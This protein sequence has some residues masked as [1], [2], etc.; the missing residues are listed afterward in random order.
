MCQK[1]MRKGLL[2]YLLAYKMFHRHRPT[3]FLMGSH[4][5]ICSLNWHSPWM[6]DHVL[7]MCTSL[8]LW[9]PHSCSAACSDILYRISLWPKFILRIMAHLHH[10]STLN[11]FNLKW[12]ERRLYLKKIFPSSDTFALCCWF[13][14][15]WLF[16]NIFMLYNYV[17]CTYLI[18][19]LIYR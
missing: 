12:A 17:G 4:R 8:D 9:L 1:F 10:S 16:Q 18:P 13:D 19:S 6:K 5:Y 14:Q 2:K 11:F 7:F 3:L 15:Q